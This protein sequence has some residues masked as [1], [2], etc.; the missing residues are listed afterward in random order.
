ME[1]S[2]AMPVP[3]A[4]SSSGL[5]ASIPASEKLPIGPFTSIAAP[6]WM[7]PRW[8]PGPALLIDLH[9]EFEAA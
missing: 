2:G 3:P 8:R 4:T 6:A 9:E 5:D 7:W 1:R